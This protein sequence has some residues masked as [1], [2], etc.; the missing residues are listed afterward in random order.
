M[1][2]RLAANSSRGTCCLGFSSAGTQGCQACPAVKV[3]TAT[4]G[5]LPSG[6]RGRRPAGLSQPSSLP[7]FLLRREQQDQVEIGDRVPFSPVGLHRAPHPALNNTQ[8]KPKTDCW[9]RG[10]PWAAGHC[11]SPES[12]VHFA[13]VKENVLCA[14]SA[15]VPCVDLFPPH[16]GAEARW[17]PRDPGSATSD[18]KVPALFVTQVAVS[19]LWLL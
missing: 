10:S 12:R 9:L 15:C 8:H 4:L 7:G 2:L 1:E 13:G 16:P 6:G 17:L 11:D 19:C 5:T 18:S 3:G 14:C